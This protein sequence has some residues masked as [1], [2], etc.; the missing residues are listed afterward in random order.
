[1]LLSGAAMIGLLASATAAAAETI[2][3]A[4]CRTPAI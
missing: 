3:T 1:M 2:N 4:G